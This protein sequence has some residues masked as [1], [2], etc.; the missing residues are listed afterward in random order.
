MRNATAV[1]TG[2]ANPTMV[3]LWVIRHKAAVVAVSHDR[4]LRAKFMPEHVGTWRHGMF[5]RGSQKR[6][7]E[8]SGLSGLEMKGC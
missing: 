3:Y 1:M 4:P 5:A 6:D 2:T 8:G 7:S